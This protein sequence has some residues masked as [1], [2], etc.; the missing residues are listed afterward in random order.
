MI[1]LAASMFDLSGIA[2]SAVDIGETLFF[3]IGALVATLVVYGLAK[4]RRL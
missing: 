2:N 4:R 1:T 3:V